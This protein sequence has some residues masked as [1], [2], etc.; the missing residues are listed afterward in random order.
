[1]NDGLADVDRRVV[2]TKQ[3]LRALDEG[4][5]AHATVAHAAALL[6]TK[7]VVGRD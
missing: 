5:V 3:G 4:T 2:G 7:H 1:M 6:H